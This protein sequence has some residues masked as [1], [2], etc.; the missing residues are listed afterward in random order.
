MT[1]NQSV[2]RHNAVTWEGGS[3]ESRSRRPPDHNN[4][5]RRKWGRKREK[6]GSKEEEREHVFLMEESYEGPDQK[7][8]GERTKHTHHANPCQERGNFSM[9]RSR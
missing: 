8:K 6:E 5:I 1:N 3:G 4:N 9:R 2:K 7:V